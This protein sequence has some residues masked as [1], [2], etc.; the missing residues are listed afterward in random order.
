MK[1]GVHLEGSGLLTIIVRIPLT[2]YPL[3]C[4]ASLL[5]KLSNLIVS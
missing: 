4:V 5:A 2:S 1:P 3:Y